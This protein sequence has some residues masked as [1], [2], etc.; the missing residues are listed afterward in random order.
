MCNAKRNYYITV[1]QTCT[2]NNRNLWKYLRELDPT[3]SAPPPPKLNDGEA[4]LK[5]VIK[6]ATRFNNFVSKITQNYLSDDNQPA[7]NYEK[8]K[9]FIASKLPSGVK[10]KKT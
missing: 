8:H 1:I 2:S 10:F 9:T 4:E 3:S 7:P 5:D 6:I